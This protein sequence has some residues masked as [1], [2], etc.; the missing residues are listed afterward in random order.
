MDD[1]KYEAGKRLAEDEILINYDELRN[2]EH[3]QAIIDSLPYPCFILNTYR[4]VVYA[5]KTLL[6]KGGINIIQSLLGK[7]PGEILA[8]VNAVS[9]EG[10]GTSDGCKFCGAFNSIIYCLKNNQQYTDECRVHAMVNGQNIYYDY[11]VTASP[12][13]YGKNQYVVFSLIDISDEKR[14]K[15]FEKIF[16]HDV[17]NKVGSLNGLIEVLKNNCLQDKHGEYIQML[18]ILGNSISQ[19]ILAH[20]QLLSAENGEL[21]LNISNFSAQQ[22][23]NETVNI[24]KQNNVALKKNVEIAFDLKDFIINS[25]EIILQRIVLN[26]LKNGLESVNLN[27]TVSIG[28]VQESNE[29]KI[30]VNNPGVIAEDIQKQIFLRSFS[31]KGSNRGLGTYSMKLLGENY[32]KG[33]VD[34]TSNEKDGTTFFIKLPAKENGSELQANS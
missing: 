18:E 15:A 12:F 24:I 29:T 33:K 6:G 26:M 20:K 30:W 9:K 8:C 21:K 25:D 28:C 5:S 2:V 13:Y 32:L 31:T 3:I 23:I 27:H 1:S 4:Q 34:F 11:R 22:F 16:F 7:R 19:E 17:D 14:R 10:C